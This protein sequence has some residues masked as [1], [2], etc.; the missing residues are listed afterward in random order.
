[1][2][3]RSSSSP[4]NARPSVKA[5]P[6][7]TPTPDSHGHGPGSTAEPHA[8]AAAGAA[9][10]PAAGVRIL[11]K[12]PNRRLYDT[13][14]SSYITLSDVKQMV[15][16]A[17]PFQ[18]RDAKT[19]DDLTR[20]ILL[21]IILEEEASGYPMFSTDMLA[22]LIRFYGHTLQGAMGHMLET[23][24]RHFVD[25]Q[26]R[27]MGG[28]NLFDAGVPKPEVWTEAVSQSAS[29]VPNFW[30]SYLED[31]KSTLEAMQQRWLEQMQ[32]ASQGLFPGTGPKR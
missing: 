29:A 11:K 1:M 9:E 2:S 27:M 6:E 8:S 22:L 23:N 30:N 17:E 25:F 4:R 18:V 19:D 26:Q 13:R 14:T 7:G 15:L 21:Q 32:Q 28:A 20:S 24:L 3:K 5:A 16:R 31:S 10:A 12:Y